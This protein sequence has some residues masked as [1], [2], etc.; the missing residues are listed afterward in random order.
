MDKLSF[1][2]V[3]RT[4]AILAAFSRGDAPSDELARDEAPSAIVVCPAL[5]MRERPALWHI[6][7]M[8][9]ARICAWRS[10]AA[11]RTGWDTPVTHPTGW[12]VLQ[13]PAI[14]SRKQGAGGPPL[15]SHFAFSAD[16]DLH[17]TQPGSA[18][19]NFVR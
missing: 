11:Q 2:S 19:S 9:W 18:A 15:V 8:C 6:P 4:A 7:K 17:R 13:R 12:W 16:A 1:A 3:Y 14:A 5:S 10:E